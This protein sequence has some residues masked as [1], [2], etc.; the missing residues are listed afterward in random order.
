METSSRGTDFHQQPMARIWASYHA[1]PRLGTCT[2]RR[3][4][5]GSLIVSGRE[6]GCW[7]A[8][9]RSDR[10]ATN[11]P[12]FR[13]LLSRSG[14][15][16]ANS[17]PIVQN[18]RRFLTNLAFASAAGL[19]GAAVAGLGGGGK[20]LAADAPLEITTIRIEKVPGLCNA[21]QY[22]ADE[23]LR[24]EGFSDIRYVVSEVAKPTGEKIARGEVDLSMDLAPLLIMQMDAG[25]PITL[26]AGVHAGGFQLFVN[27]AIHD[28]SD[29]KNGSVGVEYATQDPQLLHVILGYLGI[30]AAKDIRLVSDPSVDPLELFAQG[31][32]DAFLGTPPEPQELR[33]RKIGRVVVDSA[34]DRPWSQYF[35]C[36]L[37][38]NT[39]FVR[40]YPVATKRMMRAFLKATDLCVS[41]PRQ[42]A[43]LLVERGFTD[44]YDYALQMMLNDIR[45][46]TWRE[47]DP[48]D[49]LRFYAL[50]LH[51]A[52][53][54]KSSPR[55]VIA[56]HTD[57]RFLDELKRELKA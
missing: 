16:G 17:M 36:H 57:W 20:L 26:L 37:V 18:R 50:R 11:G 3:R 34:V 45:Y 48:E 21:P 13:G 4:R 25:A 2:H 53:L 47:Y 10:I 14:N 23:L 30:D 1:H 54:I 27:D 28:I 24:A 46:G 55:K 42:V 52:G 56:E 19:G 29:L 12:P 51:E 49:T 15:E 39:N 38:A 33:A 43:Q 5:P 40:Q 31:K 44:R 8:V 32:V 22:V 9:R 7:D 41:Q 35:C 6:C